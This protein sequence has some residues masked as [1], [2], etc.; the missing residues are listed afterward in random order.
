[1]KGA[2]KEFPLGRRRTY[3]TDTNAQKSAGSEDKPHLRF[4][5]VPR[6]GGFCASEMSWP[7]IVTLEDLG[8][9]KSF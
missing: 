7:E 2:P 1:M 3:V 8:C 5:F 9:D 4:I 6:K